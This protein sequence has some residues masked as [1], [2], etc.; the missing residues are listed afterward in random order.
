MDSNLHLKM[1][2]HHLT[3]V[4]DYSQFVA[5]DGR[6]TVHLTQEDWQVVADVLFRMETPREVLP[7]DIVDYRL[8]DNGR[9]IQLD[10]ADCVIDIDMM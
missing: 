2:V 10:T 3:R 5:A 4:L 7:P 1:G 6:A 8:T 9:I